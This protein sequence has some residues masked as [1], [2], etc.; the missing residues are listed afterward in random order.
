MRI[1][2]YEKIHMKNAFNP[3]NYLLSYNFIFKNAIM[4]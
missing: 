1:K 4:L 3:P 2:V